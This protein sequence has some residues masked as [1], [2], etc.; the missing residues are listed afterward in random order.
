MVRKRRTPLPGAGEGSE[1]QEPSAGSDH[2][3]RH[4]IGGAAA[5]QQQRGGYQ[6]QGGR[7]R[8]PQSGR[9]NFAGG[10][11]G[12]GH[13]TGGGR[14][15]GPSPSG[16]SRQPIPELHQATQTA[17]GRMYPPTTPSDAGSSYQ[18]PEPQET[19][20]ILEQLSI[21]QEGSTDQAVQ[22]PVPSSSKSMRFPRR[23]GKGTIGE[24]CIIKANH[25]FAELA[26]NDFHHYDVSFLV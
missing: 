13:G 22:S 15:G 6:G 19:A 17:Q 5:S 12:G 8:G 16:P 1:S 20:Q 23:P 18:P 3:S 7:G 14:R 24:K 25:F 26:D 9:G 2:G 4:N 21:Q 11:H 10:G